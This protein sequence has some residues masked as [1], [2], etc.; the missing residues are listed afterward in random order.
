MSSDYEYSVTGIVK[1][2]TDVV[3]EDIRLAAILYDANG[4]ILG[5]ISGSV[6]VGLAAGEISLTSTFSCLRTN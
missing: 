5:G 2:P 4:K 3:Q 1:N 6:N